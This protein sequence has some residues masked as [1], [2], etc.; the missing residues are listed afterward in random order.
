MGTALPKN[1]DKRPDKCGCD[2]RGGPAAQAWGR[3]QTDTDR[4]TDLSRDTHPASQ[5]PPQNQAQPPNRSFCRSSVTS[6]GALSPAE[7]GGLH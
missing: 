3:R 1:A 7:V 5:S 6:L 4:R 2:S